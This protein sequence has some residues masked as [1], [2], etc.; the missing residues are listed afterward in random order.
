MSAAFVNRF[1]LLYVDDDSSDLEEE[2]KVEPAPAP[3]AENSKVDQFRQWNLHEGRPE[4]VREWNLEKPKSH[5]NYGPFSRYAFRDEEKPKGLPRKYA[6]RDDSPPPESVK[7][8]SPTSPL[9]QA[10]SSPEEFPALSDYV[11]PTTPT[12]P[13]DDGWYPT[14]VER[15]KKAMED[16]SESEKTSAEKTQD[17]K[18]IHMDSLIP[19]QTHIP[20][21]LNL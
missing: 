13:P 16:R 18:T 4:N 11:R 14:L 2:V 7:P 19:M 20:G 6:F 5:K 3:Q 9:K 12:C 17:K 10:L 8:G 21:N 1:S 15:I